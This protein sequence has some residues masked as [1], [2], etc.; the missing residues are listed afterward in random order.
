MKLSLLNSYNRSGLRDSLTKTLARSPILLAYSPLEK[1]ADATALPLSTENR[2]VHVWPGTVGQPI[3]AVSATRAEALTM[4]DA[5]RA[6]RNG[7]ARRDNQDLLL[8]RRSGSLDQP[9]GL[10]VE[11]HACA[12]SRRGGAAVRWI[13]MTSDDRP[14]SPALDQAVRISGVR[15]TSTGSGERLKLPLSDNTRQAHASV[16]RPGRAR[17]AGLAREPEDPLP[18]ASDTPVFAAGFPRTVR[19][20]RHVQQKSALDADSRSRTQNQQAQHLQ[21]IR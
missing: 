1:K 10:R 20:A 18:A 6:R 13:G 17:N 14:E 3:T 12:R 19:Q 4:G 21:A 8:C 2:A 16:R 15:S 5:M 7:H 11:R 9:A